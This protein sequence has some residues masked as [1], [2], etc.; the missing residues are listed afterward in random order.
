MEKKSF[1][2]I[3]T[4]STET[5]V[6]ALFSGVWPPGDTIT[7]VLYKCCRVCCL[8]GRLSMNSFQ[9]EQARRPQRCACLKLRLLDAKIY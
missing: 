9:G 5:R 8:I 2:L 4:R 3:D 1:L 7:L 6:L